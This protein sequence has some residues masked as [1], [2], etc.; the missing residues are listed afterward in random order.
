MIVLT[1]HISVSTYMV[2]TYHISYAMFFFSKETVFS[3]VAE[4]IKLKANQSLSE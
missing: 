4:M 2:L 3:T 1:Y